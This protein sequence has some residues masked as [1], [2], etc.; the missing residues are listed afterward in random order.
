M[1]GDERHNDSESMPRTIT[2]RADHG[3]GEL[4]RH[5]ASLSTVAM[6]IGIAIAIHSLMPP[7]WDR[8]ALIMSISGVSVWVLAAFT[9]HLGSERAP[10]LG[11]LFPTLI[12]LAV[13]I[14]VLAFA[15][16]DFPEGYE[17]L[18]QPTTEQLEGQAH[19]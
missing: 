4:G 8:A 10:L 18:E 17:L 14:V 16:R 9:L 13:L 12:F 1:Y 3:D 11:I 7:G 15:Q 2:P 5:V 19:G 6:L